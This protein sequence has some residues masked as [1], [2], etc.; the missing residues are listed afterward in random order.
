M[1]KFTPPEWSGTTGYEAFPSGFSTSITLICGGG[2]W[3][4]FLGGSTTNCYSDGIIINEHYTLNGVP[5]TVEV[6][7]YSPEDIIK[8]VVLEP[9]AQSIKQG[10]PLDVSVSF[11][12]DP[13]FIFSLRNLGPESASVQEKPMVTV[14][15]YEEKA[16]HT[17]LGSW[18]RKISEKS[19]ELQSTGSTLNERVVFKLHG[20]DLGWL[21]W[22][23]G[24]HKL[25]ARI[26]LKYCKSEATWITQARWGTIVV[27]TPRITVS[28]KS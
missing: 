7:V 9:S 21:I 1:P 13:S 22:H 23:D 24:N 4:G 6:N 17:M 15:L 11:D 19:L 25:Y 27:E 10:D 3:L 12:L 28:V 8:N 16:I 18:D 20:S 14:E 5:P 2:G 26:T